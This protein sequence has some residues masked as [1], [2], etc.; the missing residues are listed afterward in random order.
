MKQA[1]HDGCLLKVFVV[2]VIFLCLLTFCTVSNAW[3]YD[4]MLPSTQR[5]PFQNNKFVHGRISSGSAAAATSRS[6]LQMTSSNGMEGTIEGRMDTKELESRNRTDDLIRRLRE[7][8]PRTLMEPLTAL[9]TDQVY[10]QD[11]RLSVLVPTSNNKNTPKK[12]QNGEDTDGQ[13]DAG[14][15]EQ[16]IKNNQIPLVRSRE[17]LISLSDVLVLAITAAKQAQ[18]MLSLPRRVGGGGSNGG[19]TSSSSSAVVECQLVIDPK[20]DHLRVPWKT[21]VP[22][23]LSASPRNS[24]EGSGDNNNFVQLEGLSDFALN[25]TTGKIMSHQVVQVILNGQSINGPEVGQAMQ[26][27]QSASKNLQQSPFFL[28]NVFGGGGSNDNT[29]NPNDLFWKEMRDGILEQAAT[30]AAASSRNDQTS[31]PVPA[32]V[33]VDSIQTVEGWLSGTESSDMTTKQSNDSSSK[34]IPLPGTGEWKEYVTAHESLTEFCNQVIPMLA[35]TT[36]TGNQNSIT[37]SSPILVDES[38]FSSNVTF[39]GLDG[40]TV[41]KGRGLVGNFYQSLSLARKMGTGQDWTVTKFCVLD[42]RK[43]TIAIDY[44]ATNSIPPRWKI[45]GRDMY[46]LSNSNSDDDHHAVIQEI[47]Q[48]EFQASAA[49]GNLILDSS[50]LMKNLIRAVEQ[51]RNVANGGGAEGNNNGMVNFGEV[52]SEILVQQGGNLGLGGGL[53]RSQQ[54][55]GQ[56]ILKSNSNRFSETAAANSYYLMA[57]L[58]EQYEGLF[59]DTATTDRR[60]VAPGAEFLGENVE[61]HGYLG[62]PL[63]RGRNIYNRVLGTLLSG[64][65]QAIAQ[66]QLSIVSADKKKKSP[67]KVELVGLDTVRLHLSYSFRL[68]AP[69]LLPEKIDPT[70]EFKWSHWDW[71]PSQD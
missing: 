64:T 6:I 49:D 8:L 65:R 40:S 60:T 42:W 29:R 31:L 41:M 58:L 69:R 32:I 26:A 4:M 18:S 11:F 17:E 55:N 56:T 15:N 12:N 37:P 68:A 45:Q 21:K 47:K 16:S 39:K 35:G 13:S 63:V 53:L 22:L 5:S 23:L 62:E 24:A 3:T 51:G 70:A 14:S 20:L 61:L 71:S 9:S 46:V 48:L 57:A 2:V 50:W 54:P 27:I 44:E 52:V 38:V 7:Q 43:S 36:P 67:P 59:D 19:E 30:A 66:K 28:P 25:S 10:D 33:T 34:D 1:C